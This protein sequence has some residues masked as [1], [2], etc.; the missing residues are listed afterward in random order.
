MG[1]GERKPE[2][3]PIAE[4]IDGTLIVGTPGS[5]THFST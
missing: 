1:S 3:V 2:Y 4:V 5:K